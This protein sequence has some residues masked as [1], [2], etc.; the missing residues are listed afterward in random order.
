MKE[1]KRVCFHCKK[2]MK[3]KEEINNIMCIVSGSSINYSHVDCRIEYKYT[4][5]RTKNNKK[6]LE[7]I[8]KEVMKEKDDNQIGIDRLN[9]SIDKLNKK[10][11]NPLTVRDNK[12]KLQEWILDHYSISIFPTQYYSRISQV[13]NGTRPGLTKPILS[14]HLL[15]MWKQKQSY[16]DKVN[17]HNR[18]HGKVIDGISRVYYDL[19]ILINKY[20]DYLKW[21][22]KNKSKEDVE[23]DVVLT[24]N[25]VYANLVSIKKQQEVSQLDD[26]DEW[27]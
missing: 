21:L 4:H 13:I 9:E 25:I 17:N 18:T 8:T 6:T 27:I 7:E 10:S 1:L 11:E 20:D 22:E 26:L 2:K 24:D 19:A 14:E 15:D 23:T 3:V 16:L 5:Q 12:A